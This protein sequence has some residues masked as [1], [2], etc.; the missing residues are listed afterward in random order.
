LN[1]QHN[2]AV[3]GEEH[4]VNARNYQKALDARGIK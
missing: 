4:M 2:F 1:G 3:T